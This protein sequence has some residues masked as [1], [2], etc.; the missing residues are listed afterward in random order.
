MGL[1][2]PTLGPF[3]ISA[4]FVSEFI[5]TY[6]LCMCIVAVSDDAH[7]K[8]RPAFVGAM[9]AAMTFAI[10]PIT[11]ACFNP[12]L[13]I[14]ASIVAFFNAEAWIFCVAPIVGS[15]AAAIMVWVLHLQHI[16][17]GGLIEEPKRQ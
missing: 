12:F 4:G 11:T 13:I 3:G 1:A 14:C 10:G 15:I 16:H 5:G 6:V 9:Y 7:W 17:K 2:V 8:L